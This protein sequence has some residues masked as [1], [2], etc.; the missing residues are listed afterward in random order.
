MAI[1]PMTAAAGL[2]NGFRIVLGLLLASCLLSAQAIDLKPLWDFGH[3]EESERRFR[4]ALVFADQNDALILQTQ[5]ARTYGLRGDFGTARA[6]LLSIEPQI[7]IASPEARVRYRLEYGRTLSS[8][9]HRPESQTPEVKEEARRS[10][11]AAF[12]LAKKNHLD[13]LAID[14][15]HMMA[16]VDTDPGDQLRWDEKALDVTLASDQAPARSWEASL[17]NNIGYALHEL[18]RYDAALAEFDRALALRQQAHDPEEIRIARWMVA[19]TLRSLNR[20]DEALAIELSLEYEYDAIGEP[21]AD[22][23]EELELLYRAK[24]EAVLAE[25]YA[26]KRSALR[27]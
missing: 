9:T 6:I 5:I 2:Q 3:P 25:A 14:S 12:D 15:L 20:D 17:R 27:P 18:G 16:F 4:D 7:R 19:W 21:Q 23:Y 26:Q 1:A 8:A 22:V 13:A 11:L 10:Y 24:G